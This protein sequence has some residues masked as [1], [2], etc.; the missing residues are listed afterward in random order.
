MVTEHEDSIECG[1]PADA[2]ERECLALKSRVTDLEARVGRQV[3]IIEQQQ[4]VLGEAN[5]AIEQSNENYRKFINVVA[6]IVSGE[7]SID[8]VRI[9]PDGLSWQVLPVVAAPEPEVV[10]VTGD[11]A[12]NATEYLSIPDKT[13]PSLCAPINCHDVNVSLNMGEQLDETTHPRPE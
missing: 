6:G 1:S 5:V 12:V 8:R 10:F 2:Y 4:A 13:Y 7:I 3:I 11:T 9:L